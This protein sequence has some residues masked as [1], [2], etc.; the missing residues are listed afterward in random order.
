MTRKKTD[1]LQRVLE[2]ATD[3]FI[4]QRFDDVSM[5]GIAKAAR[6]STTTMYEVYGGK[7]QLFMAA[8]EKLLHP[9]PLVRSAGMTAFAQLLATAQARIEVMSVPRTR[10]MIMAIMRGPDPLRER[11]GEVIAASRKAVR[12][13]L[14]AAIESAVAAGRL[15]PLPAEVVLDNFF[16]VTAYEPM[17]LALL[18]DIDFPSSPSR[19]L[20]SLF[21]PLV[22]EAGRY[23][24]E[25][26]LE[27]SAQD[28]ASKARSAAINATG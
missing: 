19:L 27:S 26:L 12:Q 2:V 18:E 8:L 7:E 11:Y 10:G 20:R 28:Q 5:A 15:R 17:L 13:E 3:F 22:T 25:M 1:S 16:A 23:E 24:L 4:R 6:C 9:A 14:H 21:V